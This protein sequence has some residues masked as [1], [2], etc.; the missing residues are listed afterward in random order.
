[1]YCSR[2]TA[3]AAVA[4][5][6]GMSAT[7]SAADLSLPTKAPPA[8]A[9]AVAHSWAGF[10]LGGHFGYGWAFPQI[11]EDFTFTTVGNPPRPRGILGGVQ[12]GYNWQSGSWVY[13]VDVDFTWSGV[14]GSSTCVVPFGTLTCTGLPDEYSTINARF[15]YAIDR[16]LFYVKGGPAWM[17]EG[18]RHLSITTPTCVGTPCTGN[19]ATWGWTVGAGVEYALNRNWS[20]RGEYDFLDFDHSERVTVSNGASADIFSLTRTFHLLKFGVNYNFGA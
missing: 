4:L 7:A 14:K 6:L 1:M 8:P 19:N 20:L 15:G 11:T 2:V 13:G 12:G 10:Y 16:S 9:P 3:M 18:F 17:D 5:S